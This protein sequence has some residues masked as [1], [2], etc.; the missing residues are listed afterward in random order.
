MVTFLYG[1]FGSGKT[2]CLLEQI[3]EDTDKGIHTF[4]LIPEQETVQSERMTL[5]ALPPS[6]QLSLEVLNF[7]RLYNRVCREYG[8]LS[9]RYITHPMQSLLM[10]RNLWE[11]SP[12]L[13]TYRD[14]ITNDPSFG[15]RVLSAIQEMKASGV[16]ATQMEHAAEQLNEQPLLATKLRD[17]SLIYSSYD[18]LVR[19]QYSDSA[20]D[21]AR[22]RDLLAKHSFFE[23]CHVYVDSFTS[24]TGVEYQ[25]LEQIFAQAKQVTVTIPVSSPKVRD[26]STEGI[27]RSALRL[28]QA[29][30]RQGGYREQ[31][32]PGNVRAASPAIAY[33]AEHLWM[34]AVSEAAEV[35]NDGSIVTEICDTPY[36]EAEAAAAHILSL[37]RQ[38]ARARDIVVIA[39]DA[40][41]Y[42]GILEPALEQAGI[43]FFFSEKIDLCAMAPAKLLLCALRILKYGWRRED[44]ISYIKTGLCGLTDEEI[45]LFE[46]YITTWDINGDRYLGDAFLMNP[47]GYSGTLTKRG[48][49]ILTVAN[50]AK[51]KLTAPL[52]S[53]FLRL[54][55]A[56]GHVPEL[57]RA[58]YEYM[59]ALHL[60]QRLLELSAREAARGC[61]KEAKEYAALY[62]VIL[63]ALA[64]IGT[65]LSDV[66][67]AMQELMQV[68][69]LVFAQTSIGTIPTSVDEVT[70]G[71]ASMLR[72][73]NP[74]YALIL[75][76]REGEFPA[77][78]RELRL[79]S[80]P[81]RE[82]LLSLGIELSPSEDVRMSDELMYVRRALAAPSDKLILMTSTTK[83]SGES[84]TPSLPFLRVEKLF[85]GHKAHR[86]DGKNFSDLITSPKLAV[87]H[88]RELQGT[89]EGALL[90]SALEP[91]L[92]GIRESSEQSLAQLDCRIPPQLTKEILGTDITL[93]PTALESFVRCPFEYATRYFLKLR[94]TKTAVFRAVDIGTMV[95]RVF[96]QVLPEIIACES[97]LSPES[98]Q[99]KIVEHANKQT[100][101]YMA[102]NLPLEDV[103]KAEFQ[104]LKIR[105][106]KL[107][108]L[109]LSNMFLEFQNRPITPAF[110]ELSL[111]GKDGHPSPL[112]LPLD[113]IGHDGTLRLTGTIDRVDVMKQNGHTYLRVVDYKTGTKLFSAEDIKRGLNLQ[114]L[115]Y[116]RAL[117]GNQNAEFRSRLGLDQHQ[118]I[119]PLG[120]VYLS[121][122]VNGKEYT[123]IPTTEVSDSDLM[124]NIERSGILLNDTEILSQLYD[125]SSK[126][127]MLKGM[128]LEKDG[129]LTGKAL[130]SEFGIR[131]LFSQLEDSLLR[132]TNDILCGKADAAPSP[133][134]DVSPCEYCKKKSICRRLSDE[135]RS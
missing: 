127:Y 134:T 112:L 129:A 64:D 9:Y 117:C 7:S 52:Q 15:E 65:A 31:F 113:R 67:L 87:S 27:L 16:T 90:A 128:K 54:E 98:V 77:T 91:F 56:D 121:S 28:R 26:I 93:S 123:C 100:E 66:S 49:R 14:T 89:R 125:T 131:E 116:L 42:R 1:T 110:Y 62:G 13:E 122:N 108:T 61:R 78:I 68:L 8:G 48:D 29:A 30:Q 12:L 23:G 118:E 105:L 60:E 96:E 40:E 95:H 80:E 99:E 63:Q 104:H 107:S 38:G 32:L 17:L 45:D 6:A 88:L 22:L 75:G 120:I 36:A 79:L 70:V 92:P 2:R 102:E 43:P 58:L 47:D 69:H 24:F 5:T 76:L 74:K 119:L 19:E 81:D 37:L 84:A 57:C 82:A 18:H 86:Y 35:C 115:L 132:I 133:F 55:A 73:S 3:R 106:A 4:L 124:K 101:Q 33:L 25:I 72:A 111:D 41:Q 46:E 39:R 11:L 83:A 59:E 20:D 34:P 126:Q 21:L 97:I 50:R 130:F 53:L 114:M 71:S 135:R 85:P 10:W 94:E 51:E 103:K 109:L 44:V